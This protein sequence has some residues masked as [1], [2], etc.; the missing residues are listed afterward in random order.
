MEY[1]R[2]GSIQYTLEK[3]PVIPSHFTSANE[4]SDAI[5]YRTHRDLSSAEIEISRQHKQEAFNSTQATIKFTP[6]RESAAEVALLKENKQLREDIEFYSSIADKDILRQIN[7]LE[8]EMRLMKAESTSLKQTLRKKCF[9]EYLNGCRRNQD[10]LS[11]LSRQL[12]IQF[13]N[14]EETVGQ[15]LEALLL[16]FRKED[17]ETLKNPQKFIQKE[18]LREMDTI[19]NELDIFHLISTL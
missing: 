6:R 18:I 16:K 4:R 17:E 7:T 12:S 5:I 9:D 14:D 19:Q 3:T 11:I 15:E 2:P 13:S 1:R 10:N 8:T